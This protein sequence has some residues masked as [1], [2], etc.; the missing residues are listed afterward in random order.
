[1][2]FTTKQT[3]YVVEGND[4]RLDRKMFLFRIIYQSES[5]SPSNTMYVGV[6]PRKIHSTSGQQKYDITLI[7]IM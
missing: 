7:R 4:M 3:H 1:M 6:Q 5:Y 2:I